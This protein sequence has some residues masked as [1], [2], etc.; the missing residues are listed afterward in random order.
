MVRFSMKTEAGEAG[1]YATQLETRVV[2]EGEEEEGQSQVVLKERASYRVL[3]AAHDL[4]DDRTGKDTAQNGHLRRLLLALGLDDR[5]VHLHSRSLAEA[6]LEASALQNLHLYREAAQSVAVAA[7]LL[8]EPTMVCPMGRPCI[9]HLDLLRRLHGTVDLD[10]PPHSASWR[11]ACTEVEDPAQEADNLHLSEHL[12]GSA[13][14]C[15]WCACFDIANPGLGNAPAMTRRRNRRHQRDL[16]W[17]IVAAELLH[18]DPAG[19]LFLCC[20]EHSLVPALARFALKNLR[21]SSNCQRLNKTRM[22]IILFA[23]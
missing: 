4:D 15:G 13:E 1:A 6:A 12:R 5:L 21:R 3:D 7:A 16:R 17:S 9:L 18:C 11:R 23:I 14:P 20:S 22:Y 8:E 19:W 10:H 2:V